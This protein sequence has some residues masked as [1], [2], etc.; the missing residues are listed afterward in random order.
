MLKKSYMTFLDGKEGRK[1]RRHH[2]TIAEAIQEADRLAKAVPGG[3]FLIMEVIGA[4][5]ATA[6]GGVVVTT[7][8]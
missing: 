7:A 6:E 4:V 8:V 1:P 3:N 2:A 5:T